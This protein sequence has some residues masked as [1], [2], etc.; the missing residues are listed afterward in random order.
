MIFQDL[1]VIPVLLLI[2]IF[3]NDNTSIPLLLSK[4][5]I[6]AMVLFLILW[7]I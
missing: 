4:T 7:F 3:S 6:S 5:F 2:T 1:M